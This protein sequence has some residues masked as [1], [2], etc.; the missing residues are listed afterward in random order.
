MK[1]TIIDD[2]GSKAAWL[3]EGASPALLNALRRTVIA[4]I[5]S[6]A[7]DEVEIFENTSPLFNEYLANRIG[8][9]PLSF[10]DSLSEDAQVI[11]T[12]DVEAVDE[13]RTVYSGE[14]RTEDSGVKVYSEQVPVISLGR[15]QVI[16][17]QGTAVKGIAAKHAKFQSAIA[18]Y[19]LLSDYKLAEKCSKCGSP[20][21]IREIPTEAAL[22]LS[23]KPKVSTLCFKCEEELSQKKPADLEDS[24][25]FVFTVES[26][27]NLTAKRQL[28]RAV[29]ALEEG[30]KVLE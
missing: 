19:G 11:F 26:Y 5:E 15:G 21:T 30:L 7:I 23:K 22:K 14:L 8:L 1:F 13:D 24:K 2:S 12:L 27:N 17:L 29:A 25:E 9:I 16:R 6:F 4:G 10:D 28:E 3:V 18:S 20:I